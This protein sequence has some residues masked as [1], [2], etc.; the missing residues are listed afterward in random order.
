MKDQNN[1]QPSKQLEF[2]QRVDPEAK[3][4]HGFFKSIDSDETR[5]KKYGVLGVCIIY[6]SPSWISSIL[7]LNESRLVSDTQFR[8]LKECI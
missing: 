4:N 5:K 1:L 6:Q 7:I 2:L 8:K 3:N